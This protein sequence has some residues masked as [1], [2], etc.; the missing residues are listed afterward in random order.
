MNLAEQEQVLEKA[1]SLALRLYAKEIVSEGKAMTGDGGADDFVVKAQDAIKQ[2]EAQLEKIPAKKAICA[3]LGAGCDDLKELTKVAGA[4]LLPLM[5]TGV[6][7]LPV[8]PLAFA[9]VGISIFRMSV[10]SYCADANLPGK[11]QK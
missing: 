10:A 7:T 9:A 3:A 5:L 11:S 6:I 4:A 1:G 8:T 2:A